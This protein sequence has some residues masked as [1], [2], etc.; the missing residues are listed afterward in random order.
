MY[1]EFGEIK[2]GKKR[3]TTQSNKNEATT[4]WMLKA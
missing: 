3:A 4:K 1:G 2:A